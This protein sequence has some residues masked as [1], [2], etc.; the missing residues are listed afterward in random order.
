V[1]NRS[2]IKNKEGRHLKRFYICILHTAASIAVLKLVMYIQAS[3]CPEEYVV[4][5]VRI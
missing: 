5:R 3:L 2:I 4:L 1:K